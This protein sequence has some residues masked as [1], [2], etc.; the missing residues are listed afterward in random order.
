MTWIK[1]EGFC[2]YSYTMRAHLNEEYTF[3]IQVYLILSKVFFRMIH[4]TLTIAV[5]NSF[6][7][8]SFSSYLCMFSCA[9]FTAVN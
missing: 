1:S 2:H 8:K 6:Y 3:N 7:Y 4:M 5:Y 9:I